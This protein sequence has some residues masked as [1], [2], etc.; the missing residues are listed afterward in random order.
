[1]GVAALLNFDESLSA[2]ENHMNM[3]RAAE[4]V[5]TGLVTFA[6]RDSSMDDRTSIRKG[7]ILGIENGKITVV[8]QT[9]VRAG[10]KV[11]RRLYKR[12][13]SSVITVFYGENATSA[14]AEELAALLR[15]R[16][17]DAEVSVVNGGQPIYFFIIS[18]E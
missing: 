15:S 6:A 9:P 2:Q 8:E 14:Q 12:K 18:V 5:G 7:Q 17:S 1:M 10:Y 3:L 16:C 11:A 4:K 13:S